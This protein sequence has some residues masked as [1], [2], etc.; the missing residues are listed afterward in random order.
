MTYV[1]A[2]SWHI[3]RTWSRMPGV[4]ITRCGRRIDNPETSDTLP[5]DRSCESCLRFDRWA[6]VAEPE[7]R[8][9]L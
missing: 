6:A 5:A 8:I 3:L 1:K 9:T 7:D 4:A 2:R